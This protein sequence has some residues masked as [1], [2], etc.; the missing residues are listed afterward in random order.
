MHYKTVFSITPG[1]SRAVHLAEIPVK[2]L[3]LSD[4]GTLKNTTFEA[5]EACIKR[6]GG[7]YS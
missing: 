5:M 1:R 3:T 4:V 6:Y 2:G 7:F